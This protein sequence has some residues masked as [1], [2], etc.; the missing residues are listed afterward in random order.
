M[1][2]EPAAK[3]EGQDQALPPYSPRNP[4]LAYHTPIWLLFFLQRGLYIW[5]TYICLTPMNRNARKTSGLSGQLCGVCGYKVSQ[6]YVHCSYCKICVNKPLFH[7]TILNSCIK[8]NRK[9][10]TDCAISILGAQF[11][12]PLSQ[13][14]CLFLNP[15]GCFTPL[16]QIGGVLAEL[17]LSLL[18]QYIQRDSTFLLDF[19]LSLSGELNNHPDHA[20]KRLGRVHIRRYNGK[21]YQ[22]TPRSRTR[23]QQRLPFVFVWS[24]CL[25]FFQRAR[26]LKPRLV[27]K[28]GGPHAF[29][30]NAP[31][32]HVAHCPKQ[33]TWGLA[34]SVNLSLLPH[35][36]VIISILCV[37]RTSN[38]SRE[39][40]H[41]IRQRSW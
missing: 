2:I 40:V 17:T 5:M 7:S 38:S 12:A 35:S 31:C 34:H 27:G 15:I 29:S 10:Y 23:S 21:K 18:S 9:R 13:I 39:S 41:W 16:S 14:L 28:F 19:F 33:I 11:T 37:G 20:H 26:V 8:E 25:Q 1:P 32:L 30:S 36:E 4:P 6:E 3:A 22:W 24:F